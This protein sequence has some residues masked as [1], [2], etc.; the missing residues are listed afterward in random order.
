MVEFLDKDMD[1][2]TIN[3]ELKNYL[4]K[5]KGNQKIEKEEL[6]KL[7]EVAIGSLLQE[8]ADIIKKYDEDFKRVVEENLNYEIINKS[9]KELNG[10]L[11][12]ELDETKDDNKKMAKQVQDYLEKIRKAG[13]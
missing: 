7:K 9:H 3:K 13:M 4:D 1:K 5:L 10:K 6:L 11:R 8:T 12:K 2:F